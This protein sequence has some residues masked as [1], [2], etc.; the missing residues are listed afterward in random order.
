[1]KTP[2]LALYC[3]GKEIS[4]KGYER[5]NLHFSYFKRKYKGWH[6]SKEDILFPEVTYTNSKN[7]IIE[8]DEVRIIANNIILFASKLNKNVR[9]C[10]GTQPFFAK[11]K[12]KIEHICIQEQ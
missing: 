9:V 4:Y 3:N 5:Q 12:L 8:I 2:Q 10:A 11:G 1:M 7:P 6:R